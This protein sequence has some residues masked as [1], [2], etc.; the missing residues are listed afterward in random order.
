M[1]KEAFYGCNN[2]NEVVIRK[3]LG[4]L[5]SLAFTNCGD[6]KITFEEGSQLAILASRALTDL[7]SGSVVYLPDSIEDI[8]EIGCSTSAAV[9]F[10]SPESFDIELIKDNAFGSTS[11]YYTGSTIE[12]GV[13]RGY[14]NIYCYSEY[15]PKVYNTYTSIG[16]YWHYDEN[17]IPVKWE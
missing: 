3:G 17:G 14:D 2:I 1:G 4:L 6:V 10:S 12:P 13:L 15:E 11:I 5:P 7:G 9:V 16:K 8:Y